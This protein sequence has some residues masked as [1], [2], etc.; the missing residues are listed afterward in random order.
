MISIYMV[1]TNCGD[2]SNSIEWH[3]TMS[4]EKADKLENSD[5]E[6]YSSGDGFQ[7]TELKF[8]DGFDLELFAE[9]NYITWFEDEEFDLD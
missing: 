8:P 7:C 4:P 2:G 9:V 6:R 3:K 1:I 5:L